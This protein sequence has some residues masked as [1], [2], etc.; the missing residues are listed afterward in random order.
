ME[1]KEADTSKKIRFVHSNGVTRF[2]KETERRI[3]FI[4]TLIMLVWGILTKVGF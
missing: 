1:Q 4:L 2:S 3:F